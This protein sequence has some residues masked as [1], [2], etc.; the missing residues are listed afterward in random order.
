MKGFLKVALLVSLFLITAILV[1]LVVITGGAEWAV[2]ANLIWGYVLLALA[3]IGVL[4]T[5]FVGTITHPSGLSKTIVST[6]VVV[7]VIIASVALAYFSGITSIPNSD[8]GVFDDQGVLVLAGSSLIV[9]YI[10]AA[11]TI[12][13]TIGVTLYNAIKKI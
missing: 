12:L 10:V 8:G 5:A 4:F 1:S 11:A 7:A 6:I 9:T 3:I 2:S 13:V